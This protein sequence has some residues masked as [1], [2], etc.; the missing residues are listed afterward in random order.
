VHGDTAVGAWQ[1]GAPCLAL[2]RPLLARQSMLWLDLPLGD[3]RQAKCEE[4]HER[5]DSG[6]GD[7]DGCD[8]EN[9]P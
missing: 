1:H 8:G 2:A 3:P 4:E 6:H 7:R 9:G 5:R